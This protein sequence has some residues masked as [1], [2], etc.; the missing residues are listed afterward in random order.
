MIAVLAY[1]MLSTLRTNAHLRN[2]IH[3]HLMKSIKLTIFYCPTRFYDR[4]QVLKATRGNYDRQQLLTAQVITQ[5][6]RISRL[7]AI[8]SRF[9]KWGLWESGR[10]LFLLF[11]RPKLDWKQTTPA[12]LYHI[13]ACGATFQGQSEEKRGSHVITDGHIQF[14]KDLTALKKASRACT[15]S[16]LSNC[17]IWSLLRRVAAASKRDPGPCRTVPQPL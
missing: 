12:L 4:C 11:F 14:N 3:L 8:A 2:Q 17:L 13:C 15:T 10:E 9:H 6:T 1:A 16:L 5:K 7:C